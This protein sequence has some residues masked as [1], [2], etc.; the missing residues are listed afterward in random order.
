MVVRLAELE[1]LDDL[2]QANLLDFSQAGQPPAD[3]AAEV[4]VRYDP[5]ASKKLGKAV[6]VSEQ[7]I[8]HRSAEL[9]QV[10]EGQTVK[11]GMILFAG[12]VPDDMNELQLQVTLLESDWY[13]RFGIKET[14]P[15]IGQVN[16]AMVAFSGAVA[17]QNKNIEVK[18]SAARMVMQ[19]TVYDM[20]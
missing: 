2:E 18:G 11:P 7:R 12:P 4:V 8:A 20:Y 16:K 10:A 9:M 19:V 17:L 14:V 15:G 6:T 3:V 13:P 5:W 1:V